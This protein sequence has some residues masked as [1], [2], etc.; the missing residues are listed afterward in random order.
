MKESH[1][2]K[3]PLCGEE[4]RPDRSGECDCCGQALPDVP[5]V[6]VRRD[7]DREVRVD[8]GDVGRD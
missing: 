4:S 6:F 5:G 3:C 8:C 2:V 1:R 7:P